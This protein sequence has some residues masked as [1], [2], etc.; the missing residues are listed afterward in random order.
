MQLQLYDKNNI[1]SLAWEDFEQGEKLQ[2]LLEPLVQKGTK[3]FIKNADNELQILTL[4][5]TILPIVVANPNVK[6]NTYLCSPTSQYIDL[7]QEEIDMEIDDK[8]FM[9]RFAKP[10]LKVIRAIANFC[11]F[12]KVVFINNWIL[13]TNL[14]PKINLDF[15]NKELTDFL[16]KQ[17]PKH[18]LIFRSINQITDKE[19]YQKLK[20]LNFSDVLSR[21]VFLM[22]P[23]DEKYKKKRMFKSDQKLWKKNKQYFWE[24]SEQMTEEEVTQVSKYYN[25]LY[26]N[27]YSN[28]NPHYLP[29]YMQMML[30]SNLMEFHLLKDNDTKKVEGVTAFLKRNNILTTP[31]IGYNREIPLK[32]GLYRF[33]NYRL[34]EEAIE[35]K[36]CLNM[37]SGAGN[38][39]QMRGGE[40][41]IEYNMV[42]YKHLGWRRRFPWQLLKMLSDKYAIPTLQKYG[43]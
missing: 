24:L 30:D 11:T 33:L 28:L 20:S 43:I 32:V 25:D 5:K 8:V 3:E 36:L 31:L 42:Y 29:K 21:Q 18:T 41:C 10:I 15:L 40:A 27:K 13:S 39:K 17:F 1:N 14:Y 9:K 35:K 16:A 7:A 6:R 38:F 37:S 34:M 22:N 23:K 4:G 12:E 26:L 2:V 19:I